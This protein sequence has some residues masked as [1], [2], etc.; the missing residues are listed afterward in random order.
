MK[1]FEMT[2]GP[3]IKVVFALLVLFSSSSAFAAIP[4]DQ[5]LDD[6]TRRFLTQ[7]TTWGATITTYATWLF[8]LLATISMVWTF[9]VMALRKADIGE[10]FSE[11]IRFTVTT[12]FFWWLLANGPAMAM[13]IVNSLRKI[14]ANAGGL[15]TTLEPSTPI[16]IGFDIVKKA[17]TSLSWV[18]PI[19]NLAIVLIC[20]AVVVCMAVVAANMLIALVTA[21]TMAYAGIFILGF[22]GA[23]WTSDM[24]IGYFKA[25]LSIGLELMTMTLLVGIATSVIDGF[26]ERL[27]GSSVYELLL[28]FCVCA[29]LALLISK[30]PGRV[31]ALAAGGSGA[32]VG[33]GS[34]MG[35]AAMAA[36]GAA[37]AGVAAMGGAAS[38]AGGTQALMA[39]FS[40]ANASESMGGGG[41]LI[42]AMSGGRGD[43]GG[44]GGALASAMGDSDSSRSGSGTGTGS[45]TKSATSSSSEAASSSRSKE[46]SAA[47]MGNAPGEVKSGVGL[48]AA[49]KVGKVVAGTATN[50]AQGAWDVTKA[51]ASDVK[52]AA[53]DRISETTGGKIAAAIKARNAA[54]DAS[55][56]TFPAFD[57]NSLSAGTSKSAD[58]ASEVA[59]FRD[60]GT[61]TS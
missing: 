19:D 30:I 17:F 3:S 60:R 58:P 39:A 25:M 42:A 50:F 27:D 5:L 40:K 56:S 34:V 26:Y 18:H 53:M 35:A 15:P 47:N 45:S 31:A 51:K 33:V 49:A 59:A 12:G 20:A 61:K 54:P 36:A 14:G 57:D 37:T 48:E 9:G 22:G 2:L 28:V 16:S 44:S 21:W 38:M 52:D 55:S 24:A 13:A 43:S 32:G 23:R 4:S 46:G 10:F 11:F 6:V 29:V 1:A 8:W 7:S 41:D